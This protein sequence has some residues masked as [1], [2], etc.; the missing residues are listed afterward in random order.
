[1]EP[2]IGVVVMHSD[3]SYMFFSAGVKLA[4]R[5]FTVLCGEPYKEPMLGNMAMVERMAD[6]L[7]SL[8][9]IDKVV[10]FG[11]SRG[12]TL[13]TAFQNAAENGIDVFRKEGMV[14]KFPD[15]IPGPPGIGGARPEFKPADGIMLVDANWGNGAVT[16]FSLDPAIVN[17]AD[18]RVLDPELDLFNPANGFT[19]GGSTY[20]DE[21]IAK[22]QKAQ[23]ERMNRC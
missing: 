14:V 7:R 6:Y 23:G 18:P 8:P 4:E 21:F 3:S 5:G 13:M 20:S 19:E 1:L 9:G 2:P 16:L 22:F 10:L 15:T 11:H 17:E 12:A